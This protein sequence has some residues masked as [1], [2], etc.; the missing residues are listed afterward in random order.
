MIPVPSNGIALARIEGL[1]VKNGTSYVTV[2]YVSDMTY[3]NRLIGK[4]SSQGF[5]VYLEWVCD[6][7]EDDRPFVSGKKINSGKRNQF[8]TVGEWEWPK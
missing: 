1:W 4:L 7:R 5:I 2:F 8:V 3:V 6:V